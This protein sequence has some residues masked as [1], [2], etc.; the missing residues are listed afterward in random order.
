MGELISILGTRDQTGATS[1]AINLSFLLHKLGNKKVLLLD[2][3]FS[4]PG[5][6]AFYLKTK[7]PAM[8]TD[9]ISLVGKK[10]SASMLDGFIPCHPKGVYTMQAF[11]SLMS[12]EKLRPD[13]LN[14][15]LGLLTRHF[16]AVVLDAGATWSPFHLTPFLGSSLI[17]LTTL[18]DTSLI[19]ESQKKV[20]RLMRAY[21]PRDKIILCVNRGSEHNLDKRGL[22]SRLSDMRYFLLPD[23]GSAMGEAQGLGLPLVL[24]QV[25]NAYTSALEAHVQEEMGRKHSSFELE[26][27]IQG[28]AKPLLPFWIESAGGGMP[29]AAE[30]SGGT[31]PT[32]AV[33]AQD[34]LKSKIL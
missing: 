8:A 32:G 19:L 20:T 21:V 5:D 15:V 31:S 1:L 10:V 23:A 30:T 17:Y 18:P 13:S 6:T 24:H 26:K 3:D 33:S 29:T 16:D 25:R 11:D 14:Q 22:E 7:E 27:I 9:L 28:D 12:P 2:F 4:Y 34:E